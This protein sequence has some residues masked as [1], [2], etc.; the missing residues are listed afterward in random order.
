MVRVKTLVEIKILQSSLE[1]LCLMV[2]F[3]SFGNSVPSL[4][5]SEWYR[6]LEE[7]RRV[8]DRVQ[9]SCFPRSGV[10][11]MIR[12]TL[13]KHMLGMF[14]AVSF[15]CFVEENSKMHFSSSFQI[16]PPK[17]FTSCSSTV[18]SSHTQQAFGCIVLRSLDYVLSFGG[19]PIIQDVTVVVVGYDECI[20]Q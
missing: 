9:F 8:G 7:S 4:H 2:A 17:L 10:V 11:S 1:G 13:F 20:H 15:C 6:P 19:A 16:N 12:K 5:T 18:L 14:W 3:D